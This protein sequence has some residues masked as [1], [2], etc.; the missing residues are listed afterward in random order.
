MYLDLPIVLNLFSDMNMS[1]GLA[2]KDVKM[3]HR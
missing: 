1:V 2:R 3:N